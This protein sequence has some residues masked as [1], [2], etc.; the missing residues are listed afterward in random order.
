LLSQAGPHLLTDDDLLHLLQ[1][2]LGLG[3][4]Q[5]Q[6]VDAEIA[7][8]HVRHLVHDRRTIIIRVD[9]DLYADLHPMLPTGAATCAARRRLTAR[10]SKRSISNQ[11]SIF[12]VVVDECFAA[13]DQ[14][15]FDQLHELIGDADDRVALAQL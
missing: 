9:D 1:Q 3:Q 14:A 11:R 4:L 8:F 2:V 7:T 12:I 15:S 5:A 6:R 10:R 13:D